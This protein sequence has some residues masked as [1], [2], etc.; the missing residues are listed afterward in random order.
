MQKKCQ[1]QGH[2]RTIGRKPAIYFERLKELEQVAEINRP[3]L[4]LERKIIRASLEILRED[5]R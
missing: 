4:E 5:A 2:T 1:V 3:A